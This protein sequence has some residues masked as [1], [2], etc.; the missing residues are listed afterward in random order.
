MNLIVSLEVTNERTCMCT[1]VL[2]IEG[3]Y[4]VSGRLCILCNSPNGVAIGSRF[5]TL[6]ISAEE[7]VDIII[8]GE[9][10]ASG[11]LSATLHG[12]GGV[13]RESSTY[14]TTIGITVVDIHTLTVDIEVEVVIEERWSEVEAGGNTLHVRGF[15]GTILVGITD[16]ETIRHVLCATRDRDVVVSRNGGTIDLVLPIG[17]V[18]TE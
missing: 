16:R 5:G 4:G 1:V 15:D 7:I 13:H 18:R 2:L 10:L 3:S 9:P 11:I 12:H 17:V 8:A 6:I 14:Y